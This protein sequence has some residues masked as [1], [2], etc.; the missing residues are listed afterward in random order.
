MKIPEPGPAGTH[1]FYGA[2]APLEGF[3]DTTETFSVGCF[4]WIP[5]SNGKTKR[6]PVKVRV[7][8]FC[9]EPEVVYSYAAYVCEK[10]DAGT[11]DGT[12]RINFA[13]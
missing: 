8:G 13:I 10:L 11:Y 9:D 6:G 7:K 5:A 3:R 4:E 1:A 2:C 12:K